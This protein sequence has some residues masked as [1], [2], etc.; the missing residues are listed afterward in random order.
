MGL[1]KASGI[2]I[3]SRDIGDKDRLITVLGE[4]SP[5]QNYF[6]RGIRKS[7]TRPIASTEIASLVD[8][9]YYDREGKEWKDVKE[10]H[11]VQRF[12]SIKS[13]VYGLYFLSYF[14]EIA[15]SLMPEGEDHYREA[16]LLKMA[17]LEVEK[18]GFHFG[19]LPFLKVRLFGYLGIIPVEFLCIDCGEEIWKKKE[20]DI[21]ESTLDLI[22]GDCRNLTRN[23][24]SLIRFFRDCYNVKYSE[25]FSVMIPP[26]ILF[27]LDQILNHFLENYMGK[28]LKTSKEFYKMLSD[29]LN[30]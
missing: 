3:S 12:D 8:I 15:A 17:F 18:E 6:I 28:G 5:R 23:S 30:I 14:S 4:D 9:V 25:L 13:S 2:V 7:K 19:I 10:I 1:S 20:A 11:L 29:E 24:I 26:D 22:C 16:K 27:E 21:Q